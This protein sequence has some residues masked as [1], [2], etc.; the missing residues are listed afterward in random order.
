[1]LKPFAAPAALL[2]AARAITRMPPREKV[3]RSAEGEE[4]S[5]PWAHKYATVNG[6]KLHY[7]EAGS[8]PL[9]MLLHGFPQC[10]Y[11][12]RHIIPSL[13]ARYRV[14]APDM[15]G[16]NRSEKPSGIDAYTLDVLGRD[17]AEL[18]AALGEDRAHVVGHDWGGLV[19]WEVAASHLDR[20]NRLA[21]INA[22]HPQ[23]YSREIRRNPTQLLRSLY[24]VLFQL[25]VLAEAALRLTIRL[26]LK[27]TAS[28]P[29]A[30]PDR[31]LDVYEN[32]LAQAGAATGMLNYYRAVARRNPFAINWTLPTIKVP[33]LLMWGTKDQFLGTGLT[34]DLEGWV[35]DITVR[36]NHR[37]AHWVPEEQPGWVVD[38]LLEFLGTS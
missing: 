16:Y 15:R 35:P 36:L 3:A 21:V 6:V 10:W 19:A 29:G 24:V 38:Q 27:S 34:R 31:A 37:S 30:F 9:V 20:V 13:A 22:P 32:A 23:A 26:G 25:P 1:M 17:V 8:G 33:T 2:L 11:Q 4:Y 14:V 18:I 7:V 5:G 28:V 12:W